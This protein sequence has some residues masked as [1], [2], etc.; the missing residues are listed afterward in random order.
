MKKKKVIG[1]IIIPHGVYPE[2][3]ELETVNVL[4]ENGDVEFILPSRTKGVRNPDILYMGLKWEIKCPTGKSKWTINRHFKKAS[5]QSEN[6]IFDSRKI[7]MPANKVLSS[8]KN[9][10]I[11]KNSIKRMKFIDKNGKVID[12]H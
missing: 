1:K 2:K 5:R 4:I 6:I 9:S 3:Y 12:F 7:K 11:L 10:F 8:V